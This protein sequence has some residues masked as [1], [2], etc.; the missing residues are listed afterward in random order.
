MAENLVAWAAGTCRQ[1]EAPIIDF[2]HVQ[3][4]GISIR[5]VPDVAYVSADFDCRGNRQLE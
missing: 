5:D 1:A 2:S 3:R 4:D